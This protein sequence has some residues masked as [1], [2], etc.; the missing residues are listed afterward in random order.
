MVGCCKIQVFK[1]DDIDEYFIR[2]K[3][4]NFCIIPNSKSGIF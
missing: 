2:L 3:K 1:N 4:R